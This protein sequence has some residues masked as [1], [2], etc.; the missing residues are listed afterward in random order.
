MT[1]KLSPELTNRVAAMVHVARQRELNLLDML[2][3]IDREDPA[4]S[5]PRLRVKAVGY[6]WV[7]PAKAENVERFE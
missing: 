1:T 7:L 6:R 5:K 2:W 4:P 3:K